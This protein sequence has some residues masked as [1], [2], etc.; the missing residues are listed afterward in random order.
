MLKA[1]TR[2][3]ARDSVK[4]KIWVYFEGRTGKIF[5]KTG[6]ECNRKRRVKVDSKVFSPRN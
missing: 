2:C 6:C 4:V 5:C 1:L 3:G